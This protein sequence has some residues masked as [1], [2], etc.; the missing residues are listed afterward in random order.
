MAFSITY[1]DVWKKAMLQ[2]CITLKIKIGSSRLLAWVHLKGT[3]SMAVSGL[4][5]R[6]T[7]VGT[8]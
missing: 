5:F 8:G 1:M 7:L 4:S 3:N 2:R 6:N